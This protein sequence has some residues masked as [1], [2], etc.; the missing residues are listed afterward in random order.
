MTDWIEINLPWDAETPEIPK[1]VTKKYKIT[2]REMRAAHGVTLDEAYEA[3]LNTTVVSAAAVDKAWYDTSAVIG[4][5]RDKVFAEFEA[6]GLGDDEHKPQR[7]LETCRRLKRRKGMKKVA[8]AWYKWVTAMYWVDNHPK[9]QAEWETTVKWRGENKPK[10]FTGLELNKPGT[11]IKLT[12]GKVYWIG[13]INTN[14]GVCDDCTLFESDEVV[15][16]YKPP[17]EEIPE[18]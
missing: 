5:V 6:R 15:V 2:A 17:A 7:M 18:P 16:A 9:S 4:E 14:R 10:S 11:R 1:S 13:D 12:D 3:Y 8:E